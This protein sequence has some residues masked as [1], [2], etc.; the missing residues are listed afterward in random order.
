MPEEGIT[1]KQIGVRFCGGCNPRY[2]RGAAYRRIAAEIQEL[3]GDRLTLDYAAEDT[4]YDGLLIIGGCQACCAGYA[5]FANRGPVL[6]MYAESDA[7][8]VT[9][10][11]LAL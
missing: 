8:D 4:D 10:R 6:K 1:V 3:A 2:D 11:L 5:Q 9:A 7:A